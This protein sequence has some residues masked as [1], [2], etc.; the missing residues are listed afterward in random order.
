MT[1][2]VTT[3]LIPA[4][5]DSPQLVVIIGEAWR[6]FISG[7]T[8]GLFFG[9]AFLVFCGGTALAQSR[10]VV[11]FVQQALSFH[12]AGAAI[13]VVSLPGNING[14]QCDALASSPVVAAAGALRAG[15]DI[16]VAALPSNRVPSWEITPG[17]IDLFDTTGTGKTKPGVFLTADLAERVGINIQSSN[18]P[19]ADGQA[20][21][22][23]G[24]FTYPADGRLPGISYSVV[25]PIASSEPFDQCWVLAWPKPEE[26]TD[27]LTLP[28]LPGLI[29]PGDPASTPTIVQLNTT[30]GLTFD[31]PA[32][33]TAL[34]LLPLLLTSLTIGALLGFI[35]IRLRRLEL[36]AV[37]HAGWSK[38][39]LSLQ[40]ACETILWTGIAS[41]PA[42]V[43]SLVAAQYGN[44]PDW[45]S[46]FFPALRSI[47]LTLA[48]ALLGALTATALTRESHLFRYF[49]QR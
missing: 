15:P 19:L 6:N 34:P 23:A 28:I 3:T 18:L 32:K 43:A 5:G 39:A 1:K 21:A 47:T 49:K 22:I 9:L 36:A 10:L 44:T 31:G 48:T 41:I 37:L 13:W 20:L 40:V 42:L 7:V 17:F 46:A 2:P 25:A 29:T 4:S 12:D 11:D 24:I 26:A 33:F 14:Q 30:K 38:T 45:F 8:R 16:T 27:V 35:S